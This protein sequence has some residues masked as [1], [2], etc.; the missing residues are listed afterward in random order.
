MDTQSII[1]ITAILVVPW[2]I[3]LF[4]YLSSN[5][6][7]IKNFNKLA[8]KYSL[9]NDYSKKVGM[10]NHPSSHGT[11]RGRDIKIESII[12]DSVE[13]KKVM[14][15]TALVVDCI[16]SDGFSF[17]V[18]KRKKKNAASFLNGSS[19]INDDEF[20]GKFI[21]QTN[22]ADK[23]RRVFDF[24]TRFKFDQVHSL[25]F[26]GI[27]KLEGNQVMYIEKGLLNDDTSLMRI[28]LIMHELCDIAEVMRYS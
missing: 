15:H 14:P 23:L 4:V 3:F 25:G 18:V 5:R 17:T 22:N 7:T 26:D 21:V 27:V 12:R 6:K 9:K 24:N 19:L 10:K 20:D 11:Y 8:E 28:E 13:G 1:F 2:I 16:N